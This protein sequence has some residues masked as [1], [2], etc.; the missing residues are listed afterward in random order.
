MRLNPSACL[1]AGLA[2]SAVPSSSL[3]CILREWFL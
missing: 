2:M 1:V 3:V